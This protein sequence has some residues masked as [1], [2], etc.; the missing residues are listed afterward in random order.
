MR[1]Q[2]LEYNEWNKQKND[3]QLGFQAL[4]TDGKEYMEFIM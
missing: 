1:G 2:K 3:I 4:S